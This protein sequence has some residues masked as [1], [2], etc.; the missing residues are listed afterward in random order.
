VIDEIEFDREEL[1][2]FG[3]CS[4]SEP[5]R[6]DLISGFIR[7]DSAFYLIEN[8]PTDLQLTNT[9]LALIQ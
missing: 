2:A 9:L 1:K 8:Y 5:L 4:W 7:V 3:A 6:W